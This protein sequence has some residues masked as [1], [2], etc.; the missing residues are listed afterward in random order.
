MNSALRAVFWPTFFAIPAFLVLIGLGTWQMQRLHW[1]EGLLAQIAER[2]VAAPVSLA[3]AMARIE[4]GDDVEYLRVR[5]EG[6]YDHA[7]ER[8]L[9]QTHDGQPGWHVYT[10]L[11]TADGLVLM[12]NRGFVSLDAKDPAARPESLVSGPVTVTGLVRK[13]G[14]KGLFSPDNNPAKNEWYWHDLAAMTAGLGHDVYPFLLDAEA[15]GDP[16][17]VPIDGTTIVNLPNKH[18][19]YALTWYGLAG[20]LVLVYVP[21]VLSRLKKAGPGKTQDD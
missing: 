8:T 16:G 17:D 15:G 2:T 19:G 14:T 20:T 9:F 21:F 12:V 11:I 13:P 4:A 5:A 10:P 6:T 1:K 3:D 7:H 18:F